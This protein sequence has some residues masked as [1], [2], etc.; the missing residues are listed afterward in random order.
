MSWIF[1]LFHRHT[2]VDTRVNPRNYVAT[3]QKCARC[4]R[5]RHHLY[6]DRFGPLADQN[7]WRDGKFP[8]NPEAIQ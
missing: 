4:G 3:E 6:Q 2:W 5:F 1:K 8:K 7:K